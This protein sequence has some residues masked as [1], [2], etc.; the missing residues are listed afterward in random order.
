MRILAL[1]YGKV[2]CGFAIS[3]PLNIIANPLETAET[4]KIWDYIKNLFSQYQVST[5]LIGLPLNKLRQPNEIENDIRDFIL[6]FQK[7]YPVVKIERLDESFT[8]KMAF[9]TM[10]DAGLNKKARQ[11]KSTI[12]KVSATIL[13]QDYLNYKR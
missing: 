12:D 4:K 2:R 8:S 11:N 3:D 1:D 9:Q 10:I 7:E 13:L 6:A 5:L